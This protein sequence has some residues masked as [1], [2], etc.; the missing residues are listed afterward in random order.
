M[1]IKKEIIPTNALDHNSKT[2]T[3]SQDFIPQLLEMF[4]GSILDCEKTK[5]KKKREI[6]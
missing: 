3:V 4:E 5:T 6:Y 2:W 1:G